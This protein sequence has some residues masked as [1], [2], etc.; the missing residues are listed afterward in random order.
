MTKYLCLEAIKLAP[1]LVLLFPITANAED[2]PQEIMSD[3]RLQCV[4][5]DD[6]DLNAICLE[7]TKEAYLSWKEMS[8]SPDFDYVSDIT[9]KCSVDWPG[10]VM[11]VEC[12]MSETK[13]LLRMNNLVNS[14]GVKEDDMGQAAQAC[15]DFHE[16]GYSILETCVREKLVE[17][18]GKPLP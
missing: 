7:E 12:V 6:A 14:H 3:I 11:R 17:I 9:S 15:S 8:S 16:F 2:I 10:Y 4:E 1:F 13:A 5:F 18:T